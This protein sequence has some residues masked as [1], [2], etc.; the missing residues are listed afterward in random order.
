MSTGTIIGLVL[1]GVFASLVLPLEE[2]SHEIQRK[3]TRSSDGVEIV[4]SVCGTGEPSLVFV[5]GGLADRSIWDGQ[6]RAFAPR[7]RVIA[8]DLAGHGESGRIRPAWGIPQ[9]G[10][11]VRAV[12][13]AEGAS[14]VVIIGSSL[15]GPI[16]MEAALL[17][18]AQTVVLVGVDSFHDLDRRID[19]SNARHQSEA[20]NRDFDGMLDRMV[21]A[22]FHPDTDRA[23]VAEVRRRLDGPARGL[24]SDMWASF[25]GYDTGASVRRLAAPIRCVN[26]DL[27]PTGVAANRRLK[28]DFDAIILPHTGHYP[29]LETPSLFNRVLAGLLTEWEKTR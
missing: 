18:P 2:R 11:D 13:E 16:A 26:G 7:Y 25:A 19:P 28:A 15:G 21:Q 12:V 1:I 8:L 17:L 9:F 5:H 29:M 14:R 6:V 23:L 20:W 22:I 3:T 27:F 24:F 10:Q 4:Y